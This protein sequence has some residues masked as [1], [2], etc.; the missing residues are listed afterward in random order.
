MFGLGKKK[1]IDS[2][3]VEN[4]KVD[5]VDFFVSKGMRP[6]TA[7]RASEDVINKYKRNLGEVF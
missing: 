3:F 1:E 6:E 4:A 5:L 7:I 2:S